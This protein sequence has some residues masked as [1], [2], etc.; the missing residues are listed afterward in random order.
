MRTLRTITI[1]A[2]NTYLLII[3]LN[4]SKLTQPSPSTSTD[5]IIFLQSF[6]EHFS[7]KLFNTENNSLAEI[8]PFLS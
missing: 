1:Y 6:N 5:L 4:S 3:F 8:L 2:H 7:P